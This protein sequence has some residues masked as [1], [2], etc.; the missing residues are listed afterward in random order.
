MSSELAL[1]WFRDRIDACT[2]A[3]V[4]GR[5]ETVDH[6]DAK[7]PVAQA[8]ATLRA[9]LTQSGIS[10][11]NTVVVLP[12]DAVVIR[13]LQLPQAP[14]NE[15]PD[16]VRF[17]AAVKAAAPVESLVLDYLT[18][19]G[20]ADGE[21]QDVVTFSMDRDRLQRIQN[22]CAAA[23]LTIE[24]ITLS[25]LCLVP[26]LTFSQHSNP[27]IGNAELL[28]YHQEHRVELSVFDHGVL[29]FCHSLQLGDSGS[30]ETSKAFRSELTRS[31]MAFSQTSPSVNLNRCILLSGSPHPAVREL[32]EQRFGG[33]LTQLMPERIRG[34]A[35]PPGYEV[36]QGAL[37]PPGPPQ[38]QIDLLHPRQRR[39][40]A[41]RRRL[42]AGI[43]TGV[44][45]LLCLTAYLVFYFQKSSLQS[46]VD[47]L[48]AGVTSQE[49]QLKKGKSR[50][51]DY[52]R[53]AKWNDSATSPLTTWNALQSLL[54]GTDRLYFVEFRIIP[55]AGE[56]AARVAGRGQARERED[57][58]GLNQVLS[59]HG[60]RVRPTTP[61]LGKRDP[62]YPWQFDLDVELPRSNLPDTTPPTG[63]RPA[64]TGT[65]KAAA[66]VVTGK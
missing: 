43:A 48:Q 27:T 30:P 22:V 7:V 8:A 63:A 56:V 60:F 59:D 26:Y 14:E 38:L 20:P 32:L 21:G 46:R 31:L 36:L 10:A 54:P 33:S 4:T 45:T 3:G 65:P 5:L 24:R 58:D 55:T 6:V 15:M 18:I 51:D 47:T 50:E 39:E 29:L 62:D 53:L 1:E 42:Y 44:A 41:D 66:S 16:L 52:A 17:Q 40:V 61:S 12:R 2:P 23:G 57:I 49:E 35:V 28:V 11:G 25:P 64:V 19:P 9:W 13:R 34:V 37:L